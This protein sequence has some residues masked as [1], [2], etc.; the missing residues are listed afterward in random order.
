M[1]R[2]EGATAVPFLRLDGL[3]KTF[4]QR[5]AVDNLCMDVQQGEF[6]SL[7]GPSGGGKTTTLHMIAGFIEPDAGDILIQGQSVR[8]LPSHRRG[9]A[10]VFQSYALFPHMSVF[11]NVAFGLRMRRLERSEIARRVASALS[12]VRLEGLDKRLPRELSG[13]QQQR[14][15]LARAT[16]LEPRLLLLDEPLS[17]LDPGLRRELR[18]NVVDIHRLTGMTTVLVTHDLEEAFTTSD[19]VAILG[20]GRL[21]Q[22]DTPEV[23]YTRP[24]T[25][26]VADFV[27]H[28]NIISGQSV[29]RDGKH[30]LRA[31]SHSVLIE[32]P[33][34]S[35][36]YVIPSHALR[37]AN[38]SSPPAGHTS[39]AAVLEKLEYL[40]AS[41]RFEV[42]V[43]GLRLVGEDS[44]GRWSEGLRPGAIV[45][46]NWPK[47]AMIALP[48]AP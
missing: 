12:L 43:Q 13:G 42:S 22:F 2:V 46:V 5:P 41:L 48:E 19:R 35:G 15:A 11:D 7:L 47:Q 44:P 1:A 14:V 16:V 3:G 17:N 10:M 29:V 18:E 38:L 45:Q 6:I 39:A 31:D 28:R 9:A 37:L 33:G 25:R 27:G 40:G 26:F 8:H 21:Q 23:I 20:Q 32:T 24:S 34:C 4:G 30:Y 36:T